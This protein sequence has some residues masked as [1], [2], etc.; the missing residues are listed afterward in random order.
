[1][2]VHEGR[3]Q[4]I[5]R[6][7]VKESR[8]PMTGLTTMQ[9]HVTVLP[10]GKPFLKEVIVQGD[11]EI[12]NGH[13]ENP[14]KQ[15]RVDELSDTARGVKKSQREQDKNSLGENVV[16]RG[17]GHVDLKDGVATITNLSFAVPGAD[18]LV[19]GTMKMEAR[20]SQSTSGI[21]HY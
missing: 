1:M 6:L 19:E 8:P 18:A 4:D 13:F 21:N 15:Q 20:F 12:G 3:L 11:F 2:A 16:A 10:E 9:A 7:I 5:L 17:S 14:S